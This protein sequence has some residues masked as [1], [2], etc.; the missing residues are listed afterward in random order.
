MHR[1]PSELIAEINGL[2]ALDARA[3]HRHYRAE[4][5]DVPHCA[6]SGLL[7][8][9]IAYKIQERYYGITLEEPVRRKLAEAADDGARL[10]P[11]ASQ[12]LPGTRLIR[13]WQGKDY[14]A[15]VR[16]D[17]RFEF[18]GEVF[19]SLSGIARKITGTNWNGKL[20]W[21]IK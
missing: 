18:N 12:M 10:K 20:F 9:I 15:I 19:G 1:L 2:E 6:I 17:G 11:L 3:L 13:R 4:L 14:E 21:G 7:R 8:A 5:A 16:S